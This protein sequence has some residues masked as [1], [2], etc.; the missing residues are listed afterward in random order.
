MWLLF[1]LINTKKQTNQKTPFFL[2]T[3]PPQNDFATFNGMPNISSM[4]KMSHRGI[5]TRQNLFVLEWIMKKL[6]MGYLLPRGK[7][8]RLK[9]GTAR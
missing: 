5:K 7:R 9:S 6:Q 1:C 4:K 8:R 2:H 3:G